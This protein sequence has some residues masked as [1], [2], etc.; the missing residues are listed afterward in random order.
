MSTNFIL[1]VEFRMAI[2]HDSLLSIDYCLNLY[3][4]TL[5]YIYFSIIQ[6]RVIFGLNLSTSFYI[7]FK[8]WKFY[9]NFN[10]VSQLKIQFRSTWTLSVSWRKK[11]IFS[12]H[13]LI[14]KLAVLTCSIW[15]HV[16]VNGQSELNISTFRKI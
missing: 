6:W 12:F 1:F 2:Q 10:S 15:L 8:W 13:L 4:I 16:F 3:L 11:S 5:L 9:V 14:K 7:F